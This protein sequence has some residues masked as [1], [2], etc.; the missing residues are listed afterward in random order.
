MNY[1][2]SKASPT[3][4]TFIEL[5]GPYLMLDANEQVINSQSFP[6]IVHC[7]NL[8]A[9]LRKQVERLQGHVVKLR[10]EAIENE[11]YME[12]HG[13]IKAYQRVLDLLDG[14]ND[15]ETPK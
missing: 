10:D 5:E 2:K 14:L 11:G 15:P 1:D 13:Q 4:W 7:V 6:R 9:T 12:R 8:E 3:P